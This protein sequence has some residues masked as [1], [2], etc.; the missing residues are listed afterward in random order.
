MKVAIL[1]LCIV[2]VFN[3][4]YAQENLIPNSSFEDTITLNPTEGSF[5]QNFIPNWNGWVSIYFNSL[6]A[7]SYAKTPSNYIGYQNPRTG[8]A[9][10]A[11]KSSSVLL[12]QKRTYLQTKLKEQLQIGKKYCIKMYASLGDSCLWAN[13]SLQVF[14]SNDSL[15]ATNTQLIYVQP[16][17]NFYNH[18]SLNNKTD[19]V[20]LIDTLTSIGTEKWITIGNFLPDSISEIL[21][22]EDTCYSSISGTI[23]CQSHYYIDDVSLVLV[24][25]TNTND[26]RDIEHD[27]LIFPNPAS[28]YLQIEAQDQSNSQYKI[29]NYL[30]QLV[31]QWQSNRIIQNLEL[32]NLSNGFYLLQATNNKGIVEQKKFV[33]QR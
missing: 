9:Y 28:N 4:N 25:E 2:F 7:N 26:D 31:E 8:N 21:L 11:V 20:E 33:I 32:S 29:F 18:P 13:N 3:K 22:L 24:N 19:W 27:F 5:I 23:L 10:A 30:G 12:T 16:Q 17:I 15:D 1:A 14:F 6:I